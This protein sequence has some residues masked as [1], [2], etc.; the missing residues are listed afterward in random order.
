MARARIISFSIAEIASGIT[1]GMT[2]L[3]HC[4]NPFLL[5]GMLLLESAVS[6]YAS[7]TDVTTAKRW[8]QKMTNVQK[9]L[10]DKD[11][12]ASSNSYDMVFDGYAS[13]PS[14]L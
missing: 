4:K 6:P 3:D 2:R 12:V 10:T 14:K 5:T 9:E 1:Y 11:A 8:V 13:I 7:S